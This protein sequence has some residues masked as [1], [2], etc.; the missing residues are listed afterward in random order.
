[1]LSVLL[2]CTLS[3]SL[4]VKEWPSR[5][6]PN[7]SRSESSGEVTERRKDNRNGYRSSSLEMW[8]N[9]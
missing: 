5:F 3:S 2:L 1:M 6:L 4:P 7:K 9:Y 8:S